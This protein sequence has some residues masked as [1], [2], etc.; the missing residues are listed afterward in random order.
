MT[1]LYY[2]PGRGA[3]TI[4]V[5]GSSLYALQ[6]LVGGDIETVSLPGGIVIVCN[7]EGRVMDLPPNRPL[8]DANG[9]VY[10]VLHGPF[11]VCSCDDEGDF[12]SLTPE[13]A[14]RARIYLLA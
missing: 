1:A 13:Q 11:F 6:A 5:D 7:E 12:V 10:D 4:E 2:E 8:R 3:R 14:E 9:E